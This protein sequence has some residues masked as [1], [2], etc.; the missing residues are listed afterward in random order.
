MPDR[1]ARASLK[2]L[3]GLP[4][5]NAVANEGLRYRF[6][7]L[8]FRSMFLSHISRVIQILRTSTLLMQNR[9]SYGISTRLPRISPYEVMMYKDWEI[10]AG[11]STHPSLPFPSHLTRRIES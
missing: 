3:E 5:L 10:P 9:L 1:Y 2:D 4:F 8:F 7:S 6:S 11:V